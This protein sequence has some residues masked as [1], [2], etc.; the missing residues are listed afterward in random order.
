MRILSS[1]SSFLSFNLKSWFSRKRCRPIMYAKPVVPTV[2]SLESRLT[3]AATYY[4]KPPVDF[5]DLNMSRV[6][7]WVDV[8]GNR[9]FANAPG[10]TDKVG[11]QCEF[12]PER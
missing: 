6:G 2:E 5:V 8:D 7:N 11:F 12:W 9:T 10:D 4:W 1:L 3:P